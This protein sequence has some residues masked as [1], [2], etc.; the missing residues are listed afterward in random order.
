MRR[1]ATSLL[2]IDLLSE[3]RM[4]SLPHP[5]RVFKSVRA[6]MRRLKHK[7]CASQRAAGFA[8]MMLA[9]FPAAAGSEFARGEA[10][11]KANCARCHAVG[12]ADASRHP[13]A[14][15]FRTLSQRYPLRD[16]EE[17]LAEGIVT[18]HPDMPEFMASPDQINAI[19]A[20][21]ASLKGK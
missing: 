16:L 10:L 14:P 15:P 12:R 3:E 4:P 13:N 17:A 9:V 21:I 11:V 2:A 20:Y 6:G 7:T 8:L 18:G 1:D 5:L 19:I